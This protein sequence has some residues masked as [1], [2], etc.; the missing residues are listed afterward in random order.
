MKKLVKNLKKGDRIELLDSTIG[1]VKEV[2]LNDKND[3][4]ILYTSGK[5]TFA[6]ADEEIEI[7]KPI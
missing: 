6:L 7:L 1:V 2:L 5:K 3:V 4:I